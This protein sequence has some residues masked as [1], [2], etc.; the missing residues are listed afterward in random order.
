M[1][2][3]PAW[4]RGVTVLLSSAVFSALCVLLAAR[5]P[6]WLAPVELSLLAC[7]VVWLAVMLA[8]V[9]RE[10]REAEGKLAARGLAGRPTENRLL[11]LQTLCSEAARALRHVA[12]DSE[13]GRLRERLRGA[14]E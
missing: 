9:G 2:Q 14:G 12:A 3:A 11:A 6:D 5:G 10:L 4:R 13:L 1:T 7:A 8:D